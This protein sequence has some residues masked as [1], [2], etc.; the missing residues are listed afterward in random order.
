MLA[1]EPAVL[2]PWLVQHLEPISDADPAVLA[3][4][5]LAL[6]KHDVPEADLDRLCNEQLS[7]FL[8]A[9]TPAFVRTM[10]EFVRSP[11]AVGVAPP[12]SPASRKRPLETDPAPSGPASKSGRPSSGAASKSRRDANVVAHPP[13]QQPALSGG[14]SWAFA[15]PMK[16]DGQLC[17]DY[18]V[19]G[20]CAR[21][22]ACPYLHDAF[23]TRPLPGFPPLL[24]QYPLF[25]PPQLPNTPLYTIESHPVPREP[26]FQP[27]AKP[28][29][30]AA[31]GDGPSAPTPRRR[32]VAARSQKVPTRTL[33]MENIPPQAA[34][35]QSIRGFFAKFGAVEAL[36]VDSRARRAK[37]TFGTVAEAERALSS[38]EAVFGNRFV[39]LYRA[40]EPT[41]VSGPSSSPSTSFAQAVQPI[42]NATR[43][44]G[45]SQDAS[46]PGQERSASSVF[47]RALSRAE[48]LQEN[49]M[50]QKELI[51]R[52]DSCEPQER[53]GLMA[54]LRKLAAQAAA[55][56]DDA[57]NDAAP[58]LDPKAHL[59]NLRKEATSLGILP[60]SA[61]TAGR[62]SRSSQPP[63]SRWP[64][65]PQ[66]A[67]GASARSFRLDNRSTN[68]VVG[69]VNPD[70]L[71]QLRTHLEG[72]G[73]L[74]SFD[75]DEE[76]RECSVTY[77]SRSQAER[78][79]SAGSAV[80][81]IAS[82]QLRWA[83]STLASSPVEP[84]A[85]TAHN[86]QVS[87]S[88]AE[89]G[90]EGSK[91]RTAD[92]EGV[93]GSD[94]DVGPALSFPPRSEEDEDEKSWNR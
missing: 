68:I 75:Y 61:S 44:T 60:S 90:P 38:P 85:K 50:Q 30:A 8:E 22:E 21:G 28:T 67:Q 74:S 3:D 78:A 73:T 64:V 40:Q 55:I 18:H 88:R 49:A 93:A 71:P 9:N 42:S 84:A 36:E 24:P 20:F 51:N 37:L 14:A 81:G 45:P 92:A 59:E 16:G 23:A 86:E 83:T 46:R 58:I 11:A 10:L 15:G 56:P 54:D 26:S 87:N 32:E 47:P 13:P 70:V 34:N 4:Y 62:P 17:R 82:L 77:A 48:R 72:F 80:S 91:G 76:R 7:D 6:L 52:I 79:M 12:S 25:P 5:V 66:K 19:R 39:R 89:Q 69:A 94:E 2:K 57:M 33:A 43:P 65:Y 63:P 1:V 27:P 35:E 41:S 29:P 31:R 53:A